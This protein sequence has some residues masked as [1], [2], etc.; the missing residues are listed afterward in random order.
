MSRAFVRESDQ[1]AVAQALPQRPVSEHPNLVTPEGLKLIDAQ[2]RAL[3]TAQAAAQERADEDEVAHLARELHYWAQRRATA[4]V[5]EPQPAPTVVRF[6]VRV[7]LRLA[8]GAER[9]YRLVGEDEA[10][11][12]RGLL[13]WVAPLAQVLIGREVG[14]AVEFHGGRLELVRL[15]S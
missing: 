6:G 7:T 14:E 11:P 10:D 12:A 4:R 3:E 2:L 1:D 9:V 5:I 13:S 8:D 15:E